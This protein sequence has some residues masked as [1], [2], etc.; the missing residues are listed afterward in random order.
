MIKAFFFDLDGTLLPIDEKIFTEVYFKLLCE[1]VAPLGYDPKKLIDVVWKGTEHMYRNDGSMTNK[2]AFW[3]YFAEVY[4]RERLKDMPVFDDFYA[5]DFKRLKD[6]SKPNP[7][8]RQIVEK[9]NK[10]VDKV[11]LSTNPIFPLVATKTR[12]GFV[13]L[14]PEDFTYVTTYEN[15]AYSKPNPKYF[16]E[17]LKMFDLKPEEV[18]LFGNNTYEDGECA[19]QL[20]IKTYMVGDF[21]IHHPKAKHEF[22][23]IQ[24][25]DVCSIMEKECRDDSIDS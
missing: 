9:A 16:S 8:A 6:Y 14:T 11:I 1:R 5:T 2:Q 10:L 15:S 7:Y 22:E 3:N 4:G 20:G 12:M 24:L 19:Y 18:I 23:T 13:N 21:I 25:E 17:L